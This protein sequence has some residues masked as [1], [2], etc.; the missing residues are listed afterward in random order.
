MTFFDPLSDPCWPASDTT[1]DRTSYLASYLAAQ[2]PTKR[3]PDIYQAVFNYYLAVLETRLLMVHPS[4]DEL[5]MASAHRQATAASQPLIA[6]LFKHGAPVP[7][8]RMD[9]MVKRRGPGQAQ[10]VFGVLTTVRWAPPPARPEVAGRVAQNMAQR[11]GRGAL[12][13]YSHP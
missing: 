6:E 4:L 13:N 12:L 9:W 5:A 7:M 1:G 3:Q 11:V 8:I 2:K 10:V